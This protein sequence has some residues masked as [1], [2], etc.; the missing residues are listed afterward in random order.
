MGSQ[1]VQGK[2]TTADTV[3]AVSDGGFP[4]PPV[5]MGQRPQGTPQ[6]HGHRR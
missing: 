6:V 2:V 1:G 4:E 3:D 5:R